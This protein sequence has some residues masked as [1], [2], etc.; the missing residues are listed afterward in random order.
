[1]YPHPKSQFDGNKLALPSSNDIEDTSINRNDFAIDVL[2][3]GQEEL[4][5]LD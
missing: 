5:G 1:M 2:V 4:R 3:L